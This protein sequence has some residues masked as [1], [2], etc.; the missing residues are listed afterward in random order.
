MMTRRSKR[1]VVMIVVSKK[2]EES[3]KPNE[4]DVSKE[5]ITKLGFSCARF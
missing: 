4:A 1:R 3:S 2:D 5:A